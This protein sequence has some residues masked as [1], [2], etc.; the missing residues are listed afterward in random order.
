MNSRER[1]LAALNGNA[2][3][4]IALCPNF[5]R[6]YMMKAAG[7]AGLRPSGETDSDGLWTSLP[8]EDRR[9][10]VRGYY[11]RHPDIDLVFCPTG[12]SARPEI[13]WPEFL[14]GGSLDTLLERIPEPPSVQDI[15]DAELYAYHA[16]LLSAIGK[17]T[18]LSSTINIPLA[19]VM[20]L[21][22]GF[23]D[24][25]VALMT[26][27]DLFKQIYMKLCHWLLPRLETAASVGLE[28]VWITQYY[29]GMDTIS[30]ELYRNIVLPGE[31]L[32]FEK[33][34]DVGLKTLFWF[35]GDLQPIVPDIMQNRP[36]A[37][38][39]EPG[40]KGYAVEIGAIRAA[41]GADICLCGCPDEL[42]MTEGNL[43]RIRQDIT[44]QVDRNGE[45]PLAITTPIL[46]ADTALETVDFLI[47]TVRSLQ[48]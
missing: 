41:A 44:D 45:G 25:L 6:D 17:Q 22:G 20:D 24:G 27:P 48:A 9:R 30:P 15:L 34:R 16:E 10:I 18:L 36:D 5:D 47:K 26:Q 11:D 39:L 46:K 23:Q 7:Y 31:Q 40:R 28:A 37:L 13:T 35:L 19:T 3:D 29:A 42:A 4:G 2:V 33:A 21:F 1:M 14:E 38:V 32:F 12:R 43:D 8:N